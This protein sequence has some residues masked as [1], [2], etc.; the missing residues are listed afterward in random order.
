MN[1]HRLTVTPVLCFANRRVRSGRPSGVLVVDERSVTRQLAA[2]V[3]VLTP[4]E[5][6]ATA[7]ALDRALPRYER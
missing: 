4:G 6:Q 2:G 7:R 1:R 5:I 3:A